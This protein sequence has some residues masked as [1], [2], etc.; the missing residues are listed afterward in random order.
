MV[1]VPIALLMLEPHAIAAFGM[2][3]FTQDAF[4]LP[5]ALALAELGKGGDWRSTLAQAVRNT[6][7][8]PFVIA[9]MLGVIV[10]A[11]PFDVPDFV[12][13]P[14]EMVASALAAVGLFLIGGLLAKRAN[15]IPSPGVLLPVFTTKLLIHPA[16]VAAAFFLFPIQDTAMIKGA[17]LAAS[18]PMV[19]LYAA[20]G[21]S[22]GEGED[23]A[24]VTLASSVFAFLTIAIVM[25]LTLTAYP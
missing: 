24:A 21:M 19:S 13:R 8:N 16:L 4:I 1:G 17:I 9:V 18:V 20:F 3:S 2:V 23:A 14:V 12:M 15:M 5:L 6:V 25:A 11:L 22:Y 7:R 10:A